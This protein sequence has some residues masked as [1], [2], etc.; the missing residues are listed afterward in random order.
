[1]NLPAQTRLEEAV[2]PACMDN[3]VASSLGSVLKEMQTNRQSKIYFTDGSKK[4]SST[5][6]ETYDEASRLAAALR[7]HG[8]RAGKVAAIH[9]ETS[10]AW[11]LTDLACCLVGAQSLALYPRAGVDR[12]ISTLQETDCRV[13]LSDNQEL[14]ARLR[15]AGYGVFALSSGGEGDCPCVS[16]LLAG[17]HVG[18]ASN[19]I[20]VSEQTA[21]TIVSTSGTLSDPK[22]FSVRAQPLLRTVY[23]FRSIYGMG[24]DDSLLLCLP[25][26]HLP[27][28]M[29]LYGSLALGMNIIL[30]APESFRLDVVRHQPTIMVAVPR[31][32]E[33]IHKRFFDIAKRTLGRLGEGLLS[34]ISHLPPP[35]AKR[36]LQ[37]ARER[38]T[39]R[40]M[41]LIFV[42]SAPT[43][44]RILAFLRRAGFPIYEVYG[45]TELGLIAVGR[46]GELREGYIGRCLEWVDVRTNPETDEL[47]VKTD[48]PFRDAWIYPQRKTHNGGFE[49][50]GDIA[51]IDGG[52]I[53]VLGRTKDFLALRS[54]EKIFTA[55]IERQIEGFGGIEHAVLSTDGQ[56]L[57]AILFLDMD[58]KAAL[59]ANESDTVGAF[60][61]AFGRLNERLHSWERIRSFALIDHSPTVESGCMTDT[62]KIR[63]HRVI[64]FYDS[65]PVHLV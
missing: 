28:R 16:D 21:F 17:E 33:F 40:N 26:A 13:V 35:V 2:E 32:L 41:R 5:Y 14:R 55:P 39:G 23:A 30:S 59:K 22:L 58:G 46:P 47:E 27:Q 20:A 42:G 31:V 49:G 38:V 19:D 18:L 48:H 4:R 10:Y 62:M 56:R 57:R 1:M 36:L 24:S 53:R 11:V 34:A 52:Y 60:Q 6:A 15:G 43:P 29:L 7:R 54:G 8:L 45:T 61:A 9:G 12:V 50:T 3:R 51:Q 63:R 37:P 44:P 64:E 65:A 25:L